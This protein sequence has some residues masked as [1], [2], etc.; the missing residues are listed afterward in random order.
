MKGKDQYGLFEVFK[1]G[2]MEGTFFEKFKY[3]FK[4]VFWCH[5]RYHALFVLVATIMLVWL[6][7]D[8]IAPNCR[9]LDYVVAGEQLVLTEQ[10]EVLNE[11][12]KA[13]MDDVDGDGTLTVGQQMLC[14][15][16]DEYSDNA[17][18]NGQKLGVTF[19]DDNIVLYIM[20]LELMEIYASDGAFAPLADFGIESENRFFVR[21]DQNRVF[22]ECGIPA[23]DGWYMA[24]KI[25]N[26]VRAND[27]EIQKKYMEAVKVIQLCMEP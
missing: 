24:L 12:I 26:D 6:V 20:D 19:A 23:G 25:V 2:Y 14:T 4:A 8:L 22:R 27:E 15:L 16:E 9:D 18:M 7:C 1:P 13:Q 10:L 21:V 5:F 17:Y 3:W 11:Q